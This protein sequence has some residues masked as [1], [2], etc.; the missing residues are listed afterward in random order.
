MSLRSSRS[1][2][3]ALVTLATFIDIVA[4]SVCVPVLPDL[5][6]RFGASPAV[7]GLLFASFG[8][9]LLVMAVPMGAMSDRV[10]RKWPL[11]GGMVA[12]A[13][14][15]TI[16]AGANSLPLLFAAR[17]VQGAADGVTWAVGFALVAD[18]YGP[19]DRGRV[20]GYVMSGT[21]VAVVFGPSLG[22]W[23]Y[24][25]GGI[26]L[27]FA[28]VSVVSILC[29]AG[30][31]VIRPDV[32]ARASSS[33]SIWTMVRVPPVAVCCALVT[34]VGSTMAM[35]EPVLPIFFNRQLGLGPSRIGWLFGGAA[36]ASALVPFIGGPMT[37][38]WGG[39]RVTPVALLA[40]AA[41]LP[42]MATATSFRAALALM[43]VQWL[44][45]SLVVTPSLAYMADVT[46]FIG[47]DTYGLGYGLYNAAWAVGILAGPALGGW[48]F[49]RFGLAPLVA[50]WSLTV[51]VATMLLTRVRS[52]S[53]G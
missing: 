35:L 12:L 6:R 7:I 1:T 36:V 47:G 32:A 23:L 29:A 41:W 34:L 4:Y 27:P 11:V 28:L 17:M 9:T 50:G 14:A 31:L 53:P 13:G 45:L 38:R 39:R 10:G 8:V 2:A 30:F 25:A 19:E 52:T 24:E 18:L 33:A 43:V 21:S 22:G 48:L 51:I 42:M 49:D 3:V 15:T 40:A 16:F 46:A 20:M 44:L 26:W 5:A 37:D